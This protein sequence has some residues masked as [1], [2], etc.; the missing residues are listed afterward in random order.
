MKKILLLTVLT[1]T[2]L[3]LMGSIALAGGWSTVSDTPA[4]HSPDTGV[5]GTVNGGGPAGGP[6]GNF[7]ASTNK[8]RVCHAVHMADPANRASYGDE[9]S[10]SW[11]LLANSDRLSECN[12]CHGDTGATGKRPYAAKSYV[13]K[14]EHTLGSTVIPDATGGTLGAGGLSCGDCHSVHGAGT[15]GWSA[16]GWENKIL[17]LNPNKDGAILAAGVTGAAPD[18]TTVDRSQTN[19]CSDCHNRNPNWDTDDGGGWDLTRPNSVSHV[20]GGAAQGSLEVYGSTQSVA[21]WGTIDGNGNGGSNNQD[22]TKGC[23]SCHAAPA[24]NLITPFTQNVSTSNTAS[25]FPHQ[26]KGA[27]LLFDTFSTGTTQQAAGVAGS[28]VVQNDASRVLPAMDQLCAKCHRRGGT[29][30]GGESAGV[31]ITF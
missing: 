10:P 11:R 6:H 14:G 15:I 21:G 29:I 5:W 26:T 8:C 22:T 2:A 1:V 13:V 30:T 16:G 7:S 27:K 17:R 18:T 9:G 19:F 3:S 4:T 25:S 31:G 24:N 20:Q 28:G 12:F 23:R